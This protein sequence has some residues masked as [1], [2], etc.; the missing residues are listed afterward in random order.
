MTFST[1]MIAPEG[2]MVSEAKMAL[3]TAPCAHSVLSSSLRP[4]GL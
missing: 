2:Q 1:L 3:S 4:Y